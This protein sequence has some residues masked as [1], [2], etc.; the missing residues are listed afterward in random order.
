ML[1]TLVESIA[2]V[3]GVKNAFKS[4]FFVIKF[5]FCFLAKSKKWNWTKLAKMGPKLLSHEVVHFFTCKGDQKWLLKTYLD[6]SSFD[7]L[8]KRFPESSS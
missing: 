2:D 6:S 3:H 7:I 1:Y 4:N 8:P 5:S